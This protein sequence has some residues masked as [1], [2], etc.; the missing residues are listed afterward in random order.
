MTAEAGI[1][2]YK[3]RRFIAAYKLRLAEKA[4]ALGARPET[5]GQ[6]QKIS[7]AEEEKHLSKEDQFARAVS[8]S[9][10]SSFERRGWL[11]FA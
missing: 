3:L 5:W 7:I 9:R 6:D 8:L 1:D 11:F 10:P 4:A 2:K